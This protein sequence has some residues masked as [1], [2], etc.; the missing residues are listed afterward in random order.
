MMLNRQSI[1]LFEKISDVLFI[2]LD[3]QWNVIYMNNYAETFWNK[4]R[5]DILGKSLEILLPPT[6]AST[7]YTKCLEAAQE[8]NIVHFDEYFASSQIWFEIRICPIEN[9]F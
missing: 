9:Y 2:V 6:V 4:R 5:E 1:D 8:D 3:R 7:F